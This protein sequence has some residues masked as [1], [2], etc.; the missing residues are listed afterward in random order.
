MINASLTNRDW[1]DITPY[2]DPA[3][4][5]FD[6]TFTKMKVGNAAIERVYTGAR[7]AE[8]PV[9]FGDHR[10]LLFSDIPNNR[11]LRYDEKSGKTSEFRIPSNNTNGKPNM[12][13]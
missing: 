12:R 5:S 1:N 13:N 8:G 7:W 10:C 2:P 11:I 4:E 3:I 9:W 6:P